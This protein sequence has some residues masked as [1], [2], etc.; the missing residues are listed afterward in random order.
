MKELRDLVGSVSLHE[1]LDGQP[2]PMLQLFRR[3]STAHP[4]KLPRLFRTDITFL[5]RYK[6]EADGHLAGP[7]VQLPE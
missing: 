3:A 1:A 4:I 6:P 2:A 5:R 7:F